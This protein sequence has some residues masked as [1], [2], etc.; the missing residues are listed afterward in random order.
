MKHTQILRFTQVFCTWHVYVPPMHVFM[1]CLYAQFIIRFQ[2]LSMK[3]FIGVEMN[4]TLTLT[5]TIA[6]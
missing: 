2:N 1:D 3:N 4:G 5:I 6:T